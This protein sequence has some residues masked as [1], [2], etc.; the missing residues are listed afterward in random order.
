MHILIIPDGNRRWAKKKHLPEFMGHKKGAE[1][2]LEITKELLEI[3]RLKFLTFW[4]LSNDNILKRSKTEINFLLNILADQLRG[5][6]E[7]PRYEKFGIRF[8]ALGDWKESFKSNPRLIDLIEQLQEKTKKYS[9]HHLT[10]LLAYDGYFEM[11]SA[12]KEILNKNEKDLNFESVH[13]N[14]WTKDLPEVDGIIR[15]GVENDPH[16]SAGVMMWLSGNSQYVFEEKS[17]PDFTAKLA[18]R[19]VN[20]IR[21]RE[22]RKGK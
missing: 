14:L 2:I 7:N 17:F 16:N 12:M 15:T 1:R 20:E 6:L 3:E 10:M 13:K 19:A 5:E 8:R 22:R 4:V 21:S 11:L 18:A 9:N